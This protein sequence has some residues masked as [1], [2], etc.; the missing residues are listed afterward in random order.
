M[1]EAGQSRLECLFVLFSGIAIG[2][3]ICSQAHAAQPVNVQVGQCEDF[4]RDSMVRLLRIEMA[5]RLA[6]DPAQ[7]EVEIAVDCG[8]QKVLIR[9]ENR[10]NR[11]LERTVTA[12]EARGQVGARVVALKA[13]ELLRE[14][15]NQRAVPTS[16]PSA[17]EVTA[18]EKSKYRVLLAA[19]LL[20]VNFQSPF[21]GV[22]LS[23]EAVG[24][25]PF[26]GRVGL[27]YLASSRRYDEGRVSARVLAGRV[28]VGLRD[29]MDWFGW[30]GG[31]GYRLGDAHLEG[32]AASAEQMFGGVHGLWGGPS[33]ELFVEVQG[34]AHFLAKLNVEGGVSVH[35]VSGTVSGHS[36][37]AMNKPWLSLSLA[38]GGHW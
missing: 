35:K 17:P 31:L 4:E 38:L 14:W 19:E 32:E 34:A 16:Q 36:D 30:G 8:P 6:D 12:E 13:V 7:S 33:G 29:E 25:R 37:L 26:Y 1:R 11:A 27:G 5:G 15:E 18:T 3:S 23:F 20:S 22:E 2:G 10:E 24:F 9:V 21:Y 28:E